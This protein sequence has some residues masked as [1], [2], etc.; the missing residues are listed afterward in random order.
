M[1]GGAKRSGERS[2]GRGWSARRNRR[3]GA[4]SPFAT[5]GS[6]GEAFLFM[7]E[8]PEWGWGDVFLWLS[9]DAVVGLQDDD[10]VGEWRC[11]AFL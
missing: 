5:H 10:V 4:V 6:V 9:D 7:G 2:L 3:A 11:G 1:L 8:T